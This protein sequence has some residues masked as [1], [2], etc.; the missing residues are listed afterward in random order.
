[1]FIEIFLNHHSF[2]LC[3]DT[4]LN[5]PPFSPSNGLHNK[6]VARQ[7]NKYTKFQNY[8]S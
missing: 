1:M 7:V 4:I 5:S 8:K 2:S 6:C 3:F